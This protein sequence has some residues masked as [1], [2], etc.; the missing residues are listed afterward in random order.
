MFADHFVGQTLFK[1]AYENHKK[2]A[3]NVEE[4]QR[5]NYYLWWDQKISKLKKKDKR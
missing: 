1:N 5:W 4:D 2:N 3:R